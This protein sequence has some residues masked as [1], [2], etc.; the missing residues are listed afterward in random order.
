MTDNHPSYVYIWEFIVNADSQALFEKE[1]GPHGSWVRLFRKGEG[2]LKTELYH[3][4]TNP[5]K[6]SH[7]RPVDIQRSVRNVSK[8]LCERI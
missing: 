8:S 7:R 1:Y 3:D 4:R 6:I 5:K 2:Y